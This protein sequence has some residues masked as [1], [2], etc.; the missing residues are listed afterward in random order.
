MSVVSVIGAGPIG[1]ETA[2]L[3]ANE[4]MEV[5]VYEDHSVVGEPE[6]CTGLISASGAKDLDIDLDDMLVNSVRGARIYS[7]DDILLE[8]KRRKPVALVIDRAGFDRKVLEKAKKAGAKIRLRTKLRN[9][10]NKSLFL[11]AKKG[12]GEFTKTDIVVGADGVNSTARHVAGIEI[13]REN[14]VHSIQ[15]KADGSFDKNMVEVYM[16]KFAKGFFAWVVPESESRARIGLGAVLGTNIEESFKR[17]RIQ[18]EIKADFY[19]KSSAMIPIG[20]P[21]K[22]VTVENILLVGDAAS[23]TKATSGGGIVIGMKAAQ[24]CAETIANN[25]KHRAPLQRYDRNLTEVNK[26]LSMHWRIRRY[27]NGLGDKK[28]DKM[29]EKSAK[30]G[31]P[32]FLEEHGD[33]DYPSRFAGKLLKKPKMWVMIPSALRALMG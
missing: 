31:L 5:T 2:R 20:P 1:L 16:G 7:P 29:F 17:F 28:L 13:P 3:L 9:I 33:M 26:E 11:E 6:N 19:D 22:T 32:E 24:V 27:I 18:K 4:G 15:F 21:L 10:R 25:F 23:H 30:A 12:R 14:F 8:V